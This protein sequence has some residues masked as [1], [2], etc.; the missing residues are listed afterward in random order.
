[1]CYELNKWLCAF[2]GRRVIKP[3]WFDHEYC[4]LAIG[5]AR[6]HQSRMSYVRCLICKRDIKVG[7]RGITTF[8]EHCRGMRHHRQD[9]VVRLHRGLPL[10]RRDGTLMTTEESAECRASLEG[11]AVPFIETCPSLSVM[12]VFERE[13]AGQSVWDENDGSKD[14]PE[15][16]V[17]LFVC[18]VVDALYRGGQFSGV[19]HLW[20]VLVSADPQHAV[21][22]GARCSISDV[23]VG[24]CVLLL[25]W[26]DYEAYSF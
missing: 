22:F 26:L 11:V 14:W 23:M 17:H 25:S 7:S 4:G 15:K 5:Y 9:C 24:N 10:R 18:F 13:G 8:M 6:N 16:T 2:A 21:L 12:E 3:G 19:S 1:M 20:E